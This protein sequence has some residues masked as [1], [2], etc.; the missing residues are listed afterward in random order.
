MNGLFKNAQMVAY[1]GSKIRMQK[2]YKNTLRKQAVMWYTGIYIISM[3][4]TQYKICVYILYPNSACGK[5]YVHIHINRQ[6]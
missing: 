2:S 6:G 4:R 3:G 1:I 5:V